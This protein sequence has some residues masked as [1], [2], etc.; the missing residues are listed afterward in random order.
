M[1]TGEEAWAE[2]PGGLSGV[3][4]GGPEEQVFCKQ[5]C[6][7]PCGQRYLWSPI[8]REKAPNSREGGRFSCARA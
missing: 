1:E 6:F 3:R 7:L 5:M 4:A 2:V 8:V